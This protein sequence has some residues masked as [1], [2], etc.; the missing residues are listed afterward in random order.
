MPGFRRQ[1]REQ[2]LVERRHND[3]GLPGV[4]EEILALVF[5]V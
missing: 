1:Q 4:E 3:V 5:Q 2:E